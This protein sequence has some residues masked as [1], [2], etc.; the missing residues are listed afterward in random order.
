M[1]VSL[2]PPACRNIGLRPGLLKIGDF[3]GNFFIRFLFRKFDGSRGPASLAV[4]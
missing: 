4:K 1:V 3:D 2:A